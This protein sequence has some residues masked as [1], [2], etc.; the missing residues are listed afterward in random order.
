MITVGTR[1]LDLYAI[2]PHL[3]IHG[4]PA[5]S[6]KLQVTDAN[7][8]LI[9]QSET[10]AISALNSGITSLGFAHGFFRFLID[11][12]LKASTTYGVSLVATG[13]TFAEAAYV[14]WCKDFDLRKVSA[15]YTP[16][17]GDHSAL[18]MELWERVETLRRLG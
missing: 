7:G 1:K 16:N 5:G 17:T 9:D 8:S 2:R 14:G 10:L 11:T 15:D 6:L 3:Y 18:N 4:A 12:S 13:Y